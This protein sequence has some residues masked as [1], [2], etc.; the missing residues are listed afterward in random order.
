MI[1]S[2]MVMVTA[3]RITCQQLWSV[4]Q[5]TKCLEGRNRPI[6]GR[7][8]WALAKGYRRGH[9]VYWCLS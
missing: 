5:G 2:C 4:L 8:F 3:A 6:A 9:R 1:C 7:A